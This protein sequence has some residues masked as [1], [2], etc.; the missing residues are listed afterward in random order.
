M[1]LSRWFCTNTTKSMFVKIVHPGGHIEL[2]DRPVLASEIMFRNPR[3]VV[4]YPH[5]FKQPWAVVAP[6]TELNLGQKFYVV[7]F[8]TIRKLQRL[9]FKS[10]SSIPLILEPQQA[11]KGDN[12][13]PRCCF[14]MFI[15]GIDVKSDDDSSTGSSSG[16]F[17]LSETKKLNRRRNKDHHII[18]SPKRRSSFEQWQPSLESITEE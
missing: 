14:N 6:A 17:G 9:A 4:A 11:K 8:S 13:N 7:P 12:T 3:C 10:S 2:H 5:V 15:A 1:A 16:S 18:S